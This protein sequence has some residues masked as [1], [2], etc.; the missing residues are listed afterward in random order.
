MS[1]VGPP[2]DEEDVFHGG[3]AA[4]VAVTPV[5]L[6]LVVLRCGSAV[7]PLEQVAL[8][9]GVVDRRLV[10]GTW[11]F[12]HVV[13]NP[14]TS[15][16]WSRAPSS[17]VNR[18]SFVVIVIVPLLARLASRLFSLLALLVLLAE[19]LGLAA[20]CG[21][22]IRALALLAVEDRPHRLFARGEASGNDE[23]LVRVN[24]RAAPELAHKIPACGALEEG[25]HDLGLRHAWELHTALGEASYEVP[26]RLAGFLGA[27]AQ[28]P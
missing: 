20:L 10:V 5:L 6:G 1:T 21:R 25:V 9:E 27:R 7:E 19:F 22:I 24:W 16:G 23:Q 18:K 2:E 15:R 11:P 3:E 4:G 12:Q 26:E 8:L 13:E 17:R 28:V 14:R